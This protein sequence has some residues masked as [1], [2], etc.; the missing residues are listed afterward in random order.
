MTKLGIISSPAAAAPVAVNHYATIDDISTE[1]WFGYMNFKILVAVWVR[2]PQRPLLLAEINN[3][4]GGGVIILV[5][6]Q[7][8]V[9][10]CSV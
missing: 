8:K 5:S 7:L 10:T 1:S 6:S 9:D 2:P 4:M 3:N